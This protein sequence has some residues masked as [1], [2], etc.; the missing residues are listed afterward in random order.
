MANVLCVTAHRP[1]F[2]Q[3][4]DLFIEQQLKSM[5]EYGAT[6]DIERSEGRYAVF[7]KALGFFIEDFTTYKP[8]LISV[9]QGMLSVY[10]LVLDN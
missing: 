4:L 1:R 9:Q 7:K 2:L 6:N 3:E 10:F 5:D 8:F